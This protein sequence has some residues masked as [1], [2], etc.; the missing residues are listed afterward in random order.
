MPFPSSLKSVAET[1]EWKAMGW[2]SAGRRWNA[3]LH[4]RDSKGRFIETG[5]IVRVGFSGQAKVLRAL[6][7]KKI[8]VEFPDG[9]R[10][11]V[12]TATVTMVRRPDGSKPTKDAR[13]VLAEDD[14]RAAHP[15]RGDG[16]NAPDPGDP[17]VKHDLAND[18]QD[19]DDDNDENDADLPEVTDSYEP[20]R[21]GA[22]PGDWVV[23]GAKAG[24]GDDSQ[25]AYTVAEV[26]TVDADGKPETVRV[27]GSKTVRPRAS[28]AGDG[29]ADTLIPREDIGDVAELERQ[30]VGKTGGL[31]AMKA[32][33]T[34]DLIGTHLTHKVQA[35]AGSPTVSP[36]TTDELVMARDAKGVLSKD[37]LIAFR[38]KTVG[39]IVKSDT[40]PGKWRVEAL[41]GLNRDGLASWDN[42][43][44]ALARHLTAVKAK[45]MADR[46][47]Q[48]APAG[49]P[50][51][52]PPA[53]VPKR[54]GNGTTIAVTTDDGTKGFLSQSGNLLAVKGDKG[55]AVYRRSDS[56]E[57]G[58]D[59]I[60]RDG[61]TYVRA[62]DAPLPEFRSAWAGNPEHDHGDAANDAP[63]AA[64]PA[65]SPVDEAIPGAQEAVTPT[66]A[67]D[68]SV[69][70][71][72]R[73]TAEKL[74]DDQLRE[75]AVTGPPSK[76]QIAQ[77]TLDRRAGARERLEVP[78]PD[79]DPNAADGAA[80]NT[81]MKRRRGAMKRAQD[82]GIKGNE[83]GTAGR[84]I[85]TW[86]NEG[87]DTAQRYVDGKPLSPEDY[88][89][90]AERFGTDADNNA[91]DQNTLRNLEG[92]FHALE[93]PEQ[94]TLDAEHEAASFKEG[95]PVVMPTGRQGTVID[96]NDA[97]RAR[98]K[99][100]PTKDDDRENLTWG[101][102]A[103]DL[104]KAPTRERPKSTPKTDYAGDAST[105]PE[106][107]SSEPVRDD[108]PAVVGEAPA[109]GV[110]DDRGGR[111]ASV[112]PESGAADRGLHRVPDAGQPA[113]SEPAKRQPRD[114]RAQDDDGASEGRGRSAAGAAVSQPR[115][116]HADAGTGDD[117][118]RTRG[119]SRAVAPQAA[120]DYK[121]ESQGD[122][123]PSSEKDR[124]AANMAALRLL[125]KIEA[126][127]R[128]AT[129]DEQ[130]V[131]AAFGGWGALPKVFVTGNDTYAKERD[132]LKTLMSPE[133]YEDAMTNALNAH[134]TDAELVKPMWAGLEALGFTGGDVLEAGS[135]T[136]NF[137][138]FAPEGAR[139]H[140]VEKN[141]VTAGIAKLLYPSADVRNESFGDTPVR[142]GMYDAMIGNVPFGNFAVHDPA[143]NPKNQ[144]KIHDHFIAK[145]ITGLKPGGIAAIITSAGTMD[146]QNTQA[147]RKIA[148]QA[149]LIGAVRLPGNA[150]K[151]AA[152]TDVVTDMLIFRK[153]KDGE[154][155]G[156]QSWVESTEGALDDGTSRS[157]NRYFQEH[158]ENILGTTGTDSGRFA[159]SD[160][161]AVK[162]DPKQAPVQLAERM[163]AI[164]ADA[165]GKGLDFAPEGDSPA[166]VKK[167][168]ARKPLTGLKNIVAKQ[169]PGSFT[170]PSAR[171]QRRKR[172]VGQ[173]THTGS[174]K[175]PGKRTGSKGSV[176]HTFTMTDFDGTEREY[177]APGAATAGEVT[178]DGKMPSQADELVAL[179][180]LRDV[181]ADLRDAERESPEDSPEILEL[182]A[183]MNR[184]YDAYVAKYGA[185]NR[186]KTLLKK[187]AVKDP[188]DENETDGLV[189]GD[190]G[191]WF[192][193]VSR[194]PEMGG[195]RK[196]PTWWALTGLE[197]EYNE[198]TETATK[199]KTFTQRVIGHRELPSKAANPRD[200]IAIS[201][202]HD[203]KIDV[204]RIAG[205]LG[206]SENEAR[207]AMEGLV[208]EDPDT[209]ELVPAHIYL[210]GEVRKRARKVAALA[211]ED[212]KWEPNARALAAVVPPDK[213]PTKITTKLGAAW[214][215]PRDFQAFVHELTGNTSSYVEHKDDG[216]WTV[217]VGSGGSR[218]PSVEG[219]SGMWAGPD[220]VAGTPL[221][222]KWG[223]SRRN[224]YQLVEA[225]LRGNRA[226]VK[227]KDIEGKEYLNQKET[228]AANAVIDSLQKEFAKWLWREPARRDRLHQA[229]NDRY[230]AHTDVNYV[231]SPMGLY[232]GMSDA[233]DLDGHQNDAVAMAKDS[234]SVLLHHEVG[235]GKTFTMAAAIMEK[236][237]LGQVSKPVLVVP[238]HM[239]EQFV[240]EFK[241]LY[242]DSNLLAD[243]GKTGG[244]DGRRRFVAQAAGHDWDA[245]VM[246]KSA[247]GRLPLSEATM[248]ESIEADLDNLREQRD[249]ALSE[250]KT[251]AVKKFGAQ[252]EARRAKLKDLQERLNSDTGALDFETAGFDYVVVDEAH[253][254]KNDLV[255]SSIRGLAKVTPN[256]QAV[257]LRQKLDFLRARNKETG[258]NSV[259][260]FATGT[261]V[262][263]S[264]REF[265]VM[266]RFLRPDLLEEAGV[267]DFDDF[268]KTFLEMQESIEPSVTGKI[269]VKMRE[270]DKLVNAGEMKRMWVQFTDEVTA[271]DV[272]I[273]RP[274]LVGGAAEKVVMPVSENQQKYVEHLAYRRSQIKPTFKPEPG[275]DTVVAIGT[276]GLISAVDLRLLPDGKLLDAGIDPRELTDADSK[277]PVVGDSI[278]KE[279]KRT[280]DLTFKVKRGSDED[281][282]VKGALQVVFSDKGTPKAE[283]AKHTYYQALKDYLIAGGMS[284]DE[285]AFIHDANGDQVK[286]GKI[287]DRA[288]TGEVKVL[289]GS[290]AKMGTGLNVQNRL[291]KLHHVDGAYR[292][293][294]IEQ[295]NGRAIRRGNQFDE[296]SVAYYP[297]EGSTE[298]FQWAHTARKDNFLRQF[299]KADLDATIVGNSESETATESDMLKALAAGNPLLMDQAQVDVAHRK[300][301]D[302]A[303]S[304]DGSIEY[305]QSVVTQGEAYVRRTQDEIKDLEAAEKQVTETTGDKFAFVPSTRYNDRGRPSDTL[306]ARKDAAAVLA[307]K[308]EAIA[309]PNA[310]IQAGKG[311]ET[312][313]GTMGGLDVYAHT[314]K[315]GM[316]RPEVGFS[317]APS[318]GST[319]T[320]KVLNT[321]AVRVDPRK[322]DAG[323]ITRLENLVASL[324]DRREA[325]AGKVKAKQAEM[326]VS[327]VEGSRTFEM[328]PEL[329]AL[330][331]RKESLAH[332]MRL[333]ANDNA[334]KGELAAAEDDY[335]TKTRAW[336]KLRDERLSLDAA[337]KPVEMG[338]ARTS[339]R[340]VKQQRAEQA[341]IDRGES[342]TDL[343][344]R[345]DD[346]SMAASGEAAERVGRARPAEP[347]AAPVEPSTD[348]VDGAGG[349]KAPRKP[350]KPRDPAPQIDTFD[351]P[352]DAEPVAEAPEVTPDVAE[353][354][355][356]TLDDPE[357]LVEAAEAIEDYFDNAEPVQVATTDDAPDPE[358]LT[359]ADDEPTDTPEE[360]VTVSPEQLATAA[361]GETDL[362][363]EPVPVET[364]AEAAPEAPVVQ[365]GFE[366][367]DDLTPTA[368]PAEPSPAERET[369]PRTRAPKPA[370]D[371]P[372][373]QAIPFADVESTPDAPTIGDAVAEAEAEAEDPKALGLSDEDQQLFEDEM[374]R[375]IASRDGRAKG[376]RDDTALDRDRVQS[377][378]NVFRGIGAR[379]SGAKRKA[380]ERV[381]DAIWQVSGRVPSRYDENGNVKPEFLPQADTDTVTVAPED[382]PTVDGPEGSVPTVEGEENPADATPDAPLDADEAT[383]GADTDGERTIAPAPV[384]EEHADE[385]D[386]EPKTPVQL[387]GEKYPLTTQQQ[388]IADAV[389]AENKDTLVKAKAG[390]GKTSTLE[391]IA[392]RLKESRPKDK[393][394]YVAFNKTVQ[395]E[396]SGR[397]PSNVESRTGHSLAWQWAGSDITDKKDRQ[398]QL[399]RADQIANHLGIKLAIGD[400]E[401][402]QVAQ[403]V[404]RTVDKFSNSADDKITAEHLPDSVSGL[405]EA[406]KKKLLAWANKAWDDLRDKDGK[407]AMS[408]DHIRKMWALSKPDLTKTGSG[409]KRRAT[410]LFLDEAQDTP[411]VLAKVVADQKMQKVIV[412]DADQAIYGFTGATDYLD[413]AEHD[414]DL[415]LNKSWRFGPQIADWGNRFLQVL[416]S[417][418]RVVGGGDDSTIV[419]EMEAPDAILVRSNGGMIGEILREQEAGRTVGVPKGT[420]ADLRALV[421][422]ARYLK[423]EGPAPERMHEDLAP[424][425]TWA[426]VTQ[427]ADKGE[428]PKLAMLTRIVG[429]Y[430]VDRLDQIV[431]DI[432]EVGSG[433]EGVS[434]EKSDLG[435]IARGKTYDHREAIKGAGFRFMEV[436][437]E[438]IAFGKNKGQPLKA[439]VA[440]GSDQEQ[441]AKLDA[442]K[443]A[444]AGEKPD[445]MVSTAHK[446]KGLEWD[447]VKIGDDF[448]GP[449][450]DP[451]TGEAIMPP[452]EELRLAYVAVTRAGK[453]LDPG[454][455]TWVLGYSA[456]NGDD[457]KALK[458]SAA[459]E[460]VMVAPSDLPGWTPPNGM[461]EEEWKARADAA[462]AAVA[463]GKPGEDVPEAVTEAVTD[464]L[465]DDTQR[466]PGVTDADR[467]DYTTGR[468][469]DLAIALSNLTGWPVTVVG[470]NTENPEA[471]GWVHA[472][473]TTPDGRFL[474]VTGLHD[475]DDVLNGEF[476]DDAANDADEFA[477]GADV[478]L[479]ELPTAAFAARW[480]NENND[481]ERTDALAAT[482]LDAI[483]DSAGARVAPTA[484]E[485]VTVAPGDLPTPDSVTPVT[486]VTPTAPVAV[487]DGARTAGPENLMT[488]E[489]VRYG[490][491][492]TDWQVGSI[493]TGTGVF[494]SNPKT[495][496]TRLIKDENL[497]QLQRVDTPEGMDAPGADTTPNTPEV[498]A[499][500]DSARTKY[501]FDLDMSDEDLDSAIADWR[502]RVAKDKGTAFSTARLNTLLGEKNERDGVPAADETHDEDDLEQPT[503]LEDAPV[504]QLV[505]DPEAPK[506]ERDNRRRER[507]RRRRM[508]NDGH[509]S[510]A[511]PDAL[512]GLDV[513]TPPVG[514]LGGGPGEV[515]VNTFPDGG[516]GD[517]SG[518]GDG[519]GA[520]VGGDAADDGASS[521]WRSEYN[522][523]AMAARAAEE[524]AQPSPWTAEQVA[525]RRAT[526]RRDLDLIVGTD[527]LENMDA[528]KATVLDVL[529]NSDLPMEQFDGLK[530]R[531]VSPSRLQ[532]G[533]AGEYDPA[534]DTI[535]IRSE[536]IDHPQGLLHE[537][538]HRESAQLGLPHAAYGT[539]R[540][541]QLEE[542]F[543]NAFALAHR[544]DQSPEWAFQGDRPADL[545][546]DQTPAEKA[547]TDAP[548]GQPDAAVDAA[549][550]DPTAP[551]VPINDLRESG[552]Q[553]SEGTVGPE[554]PPVYRSVGN[555]DEVRGLFRDGSWSSEGKFTNRD[556][557]GAT[558]F[559]PSLSEARG[560]D[561]PLRDQP[562]TPIVLEADVAGMPA[563]F[564]NDT[565]NTAPSRWD[566]TTQAFTDPV[567]APE[568]HIAPTVGAGLGI[569]GPI[570]ASRVKGAWIG[571]AHLT[572]DEL[573][574]VV[575]G[576]DNG[577]IDPTDT[578]ENI[579]TKAREAVNGNES[580]TVAPDEL[581]TVDNEEPAEVS[582]D[583]FD[584]AGDEPGTRG[585]FEDALPESIRDDVM[586]AITPDDS[587]DDR[588]RPLVNGVLPV[589]GTDLPW[590]G[591]TGDYSPEQID[592]LAENGVPLA[593]SI[594]GGWQLGHFVGKAD[595]DD[596]TFRP[597][598]GENGDEFSVNRDH[599]DT[600]RVVREG[601]IA[602]TATDPRT[603]REG[604]QVIGRDMDSRRDVTGILAGVSD[605]GRA[606]IR[607]GLGDLH[608][609]KQGAT[610]RPIH[611]AYAPGA[612]PTEAAFAPEPGVW[613]PATDGVLAAGVPGEWVAGIRDNGDGT[614]SWRL[615]GAPG[616][617]IRIESGEAA[618]LAEA[619][620]A[621]ADALLGAAIDT[622]QGD[623]T[624]LPGDDVESR[625]RNTAELDETVRSFKG[626]ENPVGDEPADE[627]AGAPDVQGAPA[628]WVP[629]GELE[630]GDIAQVDGDNGNGS[631]TTRVGHVLGTPEPVTVHEPGK[632]PRKGTRTTIGQTHDGEGDR[633]TVLSPAESV[634]ARATRDEDAGSEADP[635]SAPESTVLAGRSGDRVPVDANG[636][637]VFPGSVVTRGDSSGYVNETDD[638]NA[639]VRWSGKKH[640]ETV[641]AGLLTVDADQQNRPH[642]WT[643]T[644]QQ[645]K[646]GHY[647]E[648]PDG[649]RGTVESVA[650][651]D[652]EVLTPE[653]L[654]TYTAGDLSVVGQVVEGSDADT[655]VREP[656]F[657]APVS[658]EGPD[659]RSANPV[660]PD[661][662]PEGTQSVHPN[663]KPE[664]L[665]ALN[666]LGL[667]T[668]ATSPYD[669][670][671]AAARLR[672]GQ[673]ISAEQAHALAEY[674]D[675]LGVPGARGRAV[676]RVQN[677]VKAAGDRIAAPEALAEQVEAPP[678]AEP[679]VAAPFDLAHGD[680]IALP[681]PE[682]G[683]A[684]WGTV[685]TVRPQQNGQTAG[686]TIN[687]P[688][689]DQHTAELDA[690]DGAV[691]RLPDVPEDTKPEVAE[692]PE[693]D[694][695]PF[696]EPRVAER[697]NDSAAAVANAATGDEA[698]GSL[699][700]LAERVVEKIDAGADRREQRNA[701]NRLE[702]SLEQSGVDEDTAQA[703]HEA[704]ERAADRAA[705]QMEERL[706]NTA[707]D[708]EP[709][710]GESD[711]DAA[712]RWHRRMQEAAEAVETDDLVDA[713]LDQTAPE[714]EADDGPTPA[715]QEHARKVLADS[716]RADLFSFADQLAALGDTENANTLSQVAARLAGHPDPVVVEEAVAALS[717]GRGPSKV[718]SLAARVRGMFARSRRRLLDKVKSL[719]GT[720]RKAK[721]SF[722]AAI[723]AARSEW[724]HDDHDLDAL[725]GDATEHLNNGGDKPT[726]PGLVEPTGFGERVGFWREQ[727]PESS[728][729]F[730]QTRGRFFSFGRLTGA[731]LDQPVSAEPVEGMRLDRAPDGGPGATATAHLTALHGLGAALDDEA[732]A[733]VRATMPELGDN[734]GET[735]AEA[736]RYAEEVARQ[737]RGDRTDA[738]LADLRAKAKQEADDLHA[739]YVNAMAESLLAVL[740]EQRTMGPRDGARL[741][742]AGRS[743][744]ADEVKALRWAE[745]HLPSEW[746]AAMGPL[747]AKAGRVSEYNPDGSVTIAPLGASDRDG[748]GEYGASAL[749]AL[750]HHAEA[751]VPGLK[752]AEWAQHWKHTSEGEPGRRNRRGKH[753]LGRLRDLFPAVDLGECEVSRPGSHP[754][755]WHGQEHDG[756]HFESFALAMQ[757]MFAGQD[758]SPEMRHFIMGVLGFMDKES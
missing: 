617:D 9:R 358:A 220:H 637:G 542:A 328:R 247:F 372:D 127:D 86:A 695:R 2:D 419:P 155:P 447:R 117:G 375:L 232:P 138:G 688:N 218:N 590:D 22:K 83:A 550:E 230:R 524:T 612:E 723:A 308:V 693:V 59:T 227:D 35:P 721:R 130:R 311:R 256:L 79:A 574:S 719:M 174:E 287:T 552:P 621:V 132:E 547:E 78:A 468:C 691:Y 324:P 746:L 123:V 289:I 519:D 142:A 529:A 556:V 559:T 712:T 210:S 48:A 700:E 119:A 513:P 546:V 150:H 696:T 407:I 667:D 545:P 640:D 462:Y 40:K 270:G 421:E 191:E 428:D 557:E 214:I 258:R 159:G 717:M 634:A 262:S 144:M 207:S 263:N 94:D 670:Q 755:P 148:E 15:E 435:L 31:R 67:A 417:K 81:L 521:D 446:S 389:V 209:N 257:D 320:P 54:K 660:K 707:A 295:R 293:D 543:A 489:W 608:R 753:A 5:G 404:I 732:N 303:D 616:S 555:W 710:P 715:E 642:G 237:R 195:I 614:F 365:D 134:Y 175:V 406:E 452:P 45:T 231:D 425:L 476:G 131:L 636:V 582:P 589:E 224:T 115:G 338:A 236:K 520:R 482:V 213:D 623:V 152:G 514:A 216:T 673:P 586:G 39:R 420:K 68:R 758:V 43:H 392:R 345:K 729:E 692:T 268:A 381:A 71:Q 245:V 562:H 36:V 286:L 317:V 597:V 296:V 390:T 56:P 501:G 73:A 162:G 133:D 734:P 215:E 118:A 409:V 204:P 186:T 299:A 459:P 121:P 336:Q 496:A 704:A 143:H 69:D 460:T 453:E 610:V 535:R 751:S 342:V 105:T 283:A 273:E 249:D 187:K 206:V 587:D 38:G 444:S 221:R 354:I 450:N 445:V 397:M 26:A 739:R 139:M 515:P 525:E 752:A 498:G 706:R 427:E 309:G 200:A 92:E 580:V 284:P 241:M 4:P 516:A 12:P 433:I 733:R 291:S 728:A 151:A 598:G 114:D 484:P 212:P 318:G 201:R 312:F 276:D 157:I 467:E 49:S 619:K 474:D 518:A 684:M 367:M 641:R 674:L 272:G 581:P 116:V 202:E 416:G 570:E 41:G 74:T 607:D 310:Y 605:D 184:L 665:R 461:T 662:L 85:G 735:V 374:D 630:P 724:K 455:L 370:D 3:A 505:D 243:D 378:S 749:H 192:E 349:E 567:R 565:L 422:S 649:H 603:L 657:D 126:E 219:G 44:E 6:V 537:L 347:V 686:V 369:T 541:Q 149:D 261:P 504:S 260:L 52:A 635:Q 625:D 25:V 560:W 401:P 405:E 672:H 558:Q 628:G 676:K 584:G 294:Q 146:K 277:V 527:T 380:Y 290:T 418:E 244:A 267:A 306:R 400:M 203:G 538:G 205:L 701:S 136:G 742:I 457:A 436:P 129:P 483:G 413:T 593:A 325:L 141:A 153:R 730:G 702:T 33:T 239:L 16:L 168:P 356:E 208:F 726:A 181:S 344:A 491:G 503:G 64:K 448:K 281:H 440:T 387:D 339:R 583:L 30:S 145:G 727:L 666:D 298:G 699:D 532:P 606:M 549:P 568:G 588:P 530:I 611:G 125:R 363:G 466:L 396:A 740:A 301:R 351:G 93:D 627:T 757:E 429:D 725:I 190:N 18:P 750:A 638:L 233:I 615:T 531:V 189:E 70:E 629:T 27:P 577:T 526:L 668:D 449:K 714:A 490:N 163:A 386:Y 171:T 395:E 176:R 599:L 238:N 113:S 551:L 388:K 575:E 160:A 269:Q 544:T 371:A 398:G 703:V 246:T 53:R 472:G 315:Q 179:L 677:R 709:L 274:K 620:E 182:R 411:P 685:E 664:H 279:W 410:V 716:L 107:A 512:N 424:Y 399:R 21:T 357:D 675:K 697:V 393:V 591:E 437:G 528:Q 223:T 486:P 648:T 576:Y 431:G 1:L 32:N 652:V 197:S 137:I 103:T 596:Y 572:P 517:G 297:L 326:E 180:R 80:A 653:G 112:L 314:I 412:G 352:D 104:E 661:A 718:R 255:E 288:R 480:D 464:A 333:T 300:M 639:M 42:A 46:A 713:V 384:S 408:F 554:A 500:A 609:T 626:D 10:D 566:E 756:G 705:E 471:P 656:T 77:D 493:V 14:A 323:T 485:A 423:G 225:A 366:G 604:T 499:P 659:V 172:I 578:P 285:I 539:D 385:L 8:E 292:P 341:R 377:L 497:D 102:A 481:A 679:E 199:A 353:A 7:G 95:D 382:V 124:V 34:E 97:G 454:S 222:A 96:V 72:M 58:A 360:A 248:V 594:D 322:I 563:K 28:I 651:D 193:R 534:T 463:A 680:T 253:E 495:G 228:E 120:P 106:G 280:K 63:A 235:V 111:E 109:E 108:R 29:D 682:T 487:P 477:D 234:E 319:Y 402:A 595:G 368:T 362:F 379:N 592:Y 506:Q 65:L 451:I 622:N 183:E 198:D 671:Q 156:D 564:L 307:E 229:Y 376:W 327:K 166:P 683:E 164:A 167:A 744:D 441:Q 689:G 373:A 62:G 494:L 698:P 337:D 403:A 161:L 571:D 579:V 178:K 650:G 259:A 600:L 19:E 348:D 654:E 430:G 330:T 522:L 553:T 88:G 24:E 663:L 316:G 465:E 66:P 226:E 415:P 188:T 613:T 736:R 332:L 47:R 458:P 747:E 585:Q 561:H 658:P 470:Y 601:T 669:V 11:I 275:D 265:F 469:G 426:E 492:G 442:L 196:D 51:A 217:G 170:E 646:P 508:F 304:H 687:L 185:I 690:A 536:V 507:R 510:G 254:Y 720:G 89:H 618:S 711:T 443:E 84:R 343:R 573:R 20:S 394:I 23:L 57:P 359:P 602:G 90:L 647:V 355:T 678:A 158:P 169:A 252:I 135:G 140:G 644:G 364:P 632:T 731:D 98:V 361:D 76:R 278:L 331:A 511:G 340:K 266:M 334:D 173:I 110:R 414:V 754:S 533:H 165:K 475:P 282:P 75:H 335:N 434:F 509:M 432:R 154:A 569:E 473:V 177:V 383:V 681:N 633:E 329:D 55:M 313:V 100:S 479:L 251:A 478:E 211:A 438:K 240:R 61:K 346:A 743:E 737:E 643:S 101:G 50:D 147:R 488:G 194:N 523:D 91:D 264:T 540:E 748:A 694:D 13:K 645:V 250:G 60:T 548:L 655:G 82:D 17:A 738:E 128:P 37:G 722:K 99:V 302:E 624:T 305:H 741:N 502:E 456:E 87:D 391:A 708:F 350:R 242:P 631:A 122:L 271:D 439:W 321:G 745:K